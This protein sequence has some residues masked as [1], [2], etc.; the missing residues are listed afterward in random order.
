MNIK[1]KTSTKKNEKKKQKNHK[2]KS[3]I[4]TKNK[5]KYLSFLNTKGCYLF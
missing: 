3:F 2:L 4:S 1:K 5:K